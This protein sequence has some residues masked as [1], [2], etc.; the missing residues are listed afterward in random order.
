MIQ[1]LLNMKTLTACSFGL[2][3]ARSDGRSNACVCGKRMHLAQT[4]AENYKNSYFM[5]KKL[6]S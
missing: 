1:I 6:R 5:K 4:S 2:T 3:K